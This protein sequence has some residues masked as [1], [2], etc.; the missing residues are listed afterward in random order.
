MSQIYHRQY[1]TCDLVCMFS[2]VVY[3]RGAMRKEVL[4]A[5]IFG[6]ALG[7]IILF[8]INLANNS[9][10]SIQNISKNNPQNTPTPTPISTPKR[11]EIISPQDHSVVVEKSITITGKGA[12]LSNI[13]I[14][15]ESDDLI[16]SASEEGTFS[17]QINLI[18]GENTITVTDLFEDNTFETQTITVIQTNTLPE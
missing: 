14:I 13:A 6:I 10:A 4:F 17:A 5:V 12:P 15:T 8:G 9:V 18:G 3:N 11:L 2:V 16:I 1:P 7:G